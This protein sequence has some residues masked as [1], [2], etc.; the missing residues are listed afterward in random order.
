MHPKPAPEAESVVRLLG[1]YRKGSKDAASQLVEMLYPELRRLAAARMKGERPGHTWQPTA[2][3]NELYL[4]LLKIKA[5]RTAPDEAD[6]R[7]FI[8]LASHL[9]KRL[10]IHHSRPL[11]RRFEKLPDSAVPESPEPSAEDLVEIEDLL[12]RLAAINPKLRMVVEMRV[13]EGMP[14]PEIADRLGC[15][16]STVDRYW[17]FARQWLAERLNQPHLS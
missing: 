17:C 5:L 15:A 14:I 3:V 13:F 16:K 12:E 10:L 2:L 7:A 6:K 1:E 11:Y 9:M 8:G 4:E